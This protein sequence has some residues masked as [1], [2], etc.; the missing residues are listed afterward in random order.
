M[1]SIIVP[2]YNR[3]NEILALLDSLVEQTEYGF[4]VVIVDDNSTTPIQI[5]KTYPFAVNLIRNEQ[6]QGAAG[7][8]NIGAEKAKNEWLLFLDDDDRFAANKCQKYRQFIEARPD[9]NFIYHPAKCEMVNEKFSYVTKPSKPENINLDHILRA[10][11]IGGMPMIGIKKAF[12][13]ALGKLATDLK[14]LEDYEFVLKAVSHPDF[15]AGFIDEPLSICY[16]HT[17]RSSVST[18]T[19]NTEMAIDYIQQ[20]YVK[21]AEQKQHFAIN[22]LY[23]LAYPYAMNLSRKTAYYYF[24]MFRLSRN[25]KHLIIATISFISPKLAIN[26]K[27]FI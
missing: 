10:N 16:F 15:N 11:K 3:N 9:V 2:S 8:R 4:E 18:N 22:A 20:K 17:Q 25:V 12:F 14:S 5:K 24:K 13:F 19:K 7:S 27:R 26:M 1:F 6:N 23:M 21:T